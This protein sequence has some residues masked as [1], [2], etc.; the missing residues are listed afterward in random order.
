MAWVVGEFSV[1]PPSGVNPVGQMWLRIQKNT[2]KQTMTASLLSP[3]TD[4]NPYSNVPLEQHVRKLEVFHGYSGFLKM[5]SQDL[6]LY[7][8][9]YF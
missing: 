6:A 3:I 2:N 4:E 5:S 8:R 7:H 1:G 9:E